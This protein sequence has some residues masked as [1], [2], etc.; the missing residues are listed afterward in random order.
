M[1]GLLCGL[2]EESLGCGGPILAN[3]LGQSQLSD[4]FTENP[5]PMGTI[6]TIATAR[7]GCQTQIWQV[8]QGC[9][10][11]NSDCS[12]PS[13]SADRLLRLSAE[14]ACFRPIFRRP[15]RSGT[16][17]CYGLSLDS[18]AVCLCFRHSEELRVR[19]L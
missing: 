4:V 15:A 8:L 6:S 10:N 14:A 19:V 3:E 1:R 11:G 12:R 5:R 16:L 17:P 18:V 9:F 7:E 2:L 13:G